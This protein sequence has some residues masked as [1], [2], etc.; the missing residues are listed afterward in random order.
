MKYLLD[1][2]VCIEV[3]RRK[4]GPVTRRVTAQPPEDLATSTVNLLELEAGVFR[5]DRPTLERQRVDYFLAIISRL[6]PFDADAA[7]MCARLRHAMRAQPIGPLDLLIAS[8]AAVHDLTVVTHNV[9]EFGR[10][11]G[12][13]VEDWSRPA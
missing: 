12:L 5:S 8:V 11:P 6:L 13:R 3:V 4:P 10:V 2:T 1:S 9:R 7:R